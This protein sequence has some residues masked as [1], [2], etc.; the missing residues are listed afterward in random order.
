MVAKNFV[1]S[2]PHLL[3]EWDYEA[4]DVNPEDT[5]MGEK[6]KY[7]WKCANGHSWNSTILHRAYHNAGCKKCPREW[8]KVELKIDG[9]II[10]GTNTIIVKKCENNHEY[11]ISARNYAKADKPCPYCGNRKLLKGFNDLLTVNPELAKEFHKEL[12]DSSP[13]EVVHSSHNKI[14][15][16]CPKHENHVWEASLS[17]RAIIGNGCVYC[18][19]KKILKGYNDIPTTNPDLAKEWDYSKNG[20]L[21]PD[22][23]HIGS[24]KRVAWVCDKGHEW[25]T[26]I[27]H[28]GSGAGCRVCAKYGFDDSK[29]STLYFIYHKDFNAFKVGIT[30][31][32]SRRIKRYENM[33]WEIQHLIAHY[34]GT[35]IRD[36]E[37]YMLRWVR[38][39]LMLPAFLSKSDMGNNGGWVETFNADEVTVKQ[40]IDKMNI[41]NS[42]Y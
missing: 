23:F 13:S 11:K 30:N 35:K 1:N 26:K 34:E 22:M 20:D 5:T 42:E 6:T 25:S 9:E 28:R 36:L 18:G 41:L 32:G 29:P 38:K 7:S 16:Q 15:W 24:D 8:Q 27:A 33:G 4:N 3:E 37:T 21:K 17:S 14:W 19:N 31:T 12:N 40:V 10:V 2:Y 39:E